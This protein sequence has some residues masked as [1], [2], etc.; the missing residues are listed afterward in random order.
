MKE[1]NH[2]YC[3]VCT[4][5]FDKKPELVSGQLQCGVCLNSGFI[6]TKKIPGTKYL[7]DSAEQDLR[8]ANFMRDMW[9]EELKIL[10]KRLIY[11]ESD[12]Y[13]ESNCFTPDEAWRNFR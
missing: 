12:S 5:V 3:R 13:V 11:L 8:R 10:T 1:T 2:Y 9:V 4:T 6:D 7:V